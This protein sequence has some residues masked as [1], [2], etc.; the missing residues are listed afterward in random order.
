MKNNENFHFDLK[1]FKTRV[2]PRELLPFYD[3]AQRLPRAKAKGCVSF[4]GLPSHKNRGFKQ[5]KCI[6]SQ[7]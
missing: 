1:I 4:L 7:S 6:L 3:A 2:K 5:R